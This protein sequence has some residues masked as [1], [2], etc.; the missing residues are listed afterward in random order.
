MDIIYDAC[1]WWQKGHLQ[2]GLD[3]D[4]DDDDDDGEGDVSGICWNKEQDRI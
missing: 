2:A 4:D 3:S 1:W